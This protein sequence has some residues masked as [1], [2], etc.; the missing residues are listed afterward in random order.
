[1]Q[2]AVRRHRPAQK[3]RQRRP[4]GG[5]RISGTRLPN[6]ALPALRRACCAE[7][8]LPTQHDCPFPPSNPAQLDKCFGYETCVEEAQKALLAAKVEASSAYRGIGLVKL[9]G[10]H[11]GFIAVKV[12]GR[13]GSGARGKAQLSLLAARLLSRRSPQRRRS[14]DVSRLLPALPLWEQ[15]ALASGLVDVVL[16]P[17]AGYC[18]MTAPCLYSWWPGARLPTRNIMDLHSRWVGEAGPCPSSCCAALCCALQ[19]PFNMDKVL[20]YMGRILD[21][22]GHVVVCLAEGAGQVGTRGRAAGCRGGGQGKAGQSK[23]MGPHVALFVLRCGAA[24]VG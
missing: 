3:H 16:I 20:N 22:R 5:Q 17:E 12:R 10:R 18:R 13:Q 24:R 9:M 21:T 6:L 1:M 2:R 19:V 14:S 4:H 7:A 11:S 23:A 8:R 15:A